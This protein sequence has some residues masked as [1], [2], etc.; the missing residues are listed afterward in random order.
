MKLM[1]HNYQSIVK[2]EVELRQLQE[3]VEVPS[4]PRKFVLS[5]E[6]VRNDGTVVNS[7]KNL[8]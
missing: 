7:K 3:P 6:Q 4:R 5:I 8:L 1:Q 2:L